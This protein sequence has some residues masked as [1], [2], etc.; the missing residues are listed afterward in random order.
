M[1]LP[2]KVFEEKK[3]APVR[4]SDL[5]STVEKGGGLTFSVEGA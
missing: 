1:E 4:G 5:R 3:T 2:K